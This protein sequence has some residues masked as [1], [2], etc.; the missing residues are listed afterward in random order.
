MIKRQLPSNLFPLICSIVKFVKDSVSFL[1]KEIVKKYRKS[2]V[3]K[4]PQFV[5]P[6]A[7]KCLYHFKI[8]FL[9]ELALDITASTKYTV[10]ITF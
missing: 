9:E 4:L 2:M 5:S 1:Y 3:T 7:C 8:G 10:L 6:W